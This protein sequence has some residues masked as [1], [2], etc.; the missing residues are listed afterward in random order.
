MKTEVFKKNMLV[1]ITEALSGHKVPLVR[2]QK[3]AAETL[4]ICTANPDVISPSDI[5]SIRERYPELEV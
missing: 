3:M 5:A 4:H 2:A 1:A